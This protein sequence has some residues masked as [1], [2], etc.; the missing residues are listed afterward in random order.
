MMI[1]SNLGFKFSNFR[2]LLLRPSAIK[3]ALFLHFYLLI[4]N[5]NIVY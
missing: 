4:T 5:F 2:I 3:K 1:L